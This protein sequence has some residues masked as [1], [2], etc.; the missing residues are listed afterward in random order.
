MLIEAGGPAAGAVND[1][2]D[3]YF[4]RKHTVGENVWRSLDDQFASTGYP[5]WTATSRIFLKSISS[6]AD[7]AGNKFCGL[8]AVF[9]DVRD[10]LIQIAPCIATQI[11]F[12]PSLSASSL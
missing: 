10:G 6:Q 1:C 8:S 3:F 9:E 12:M 7:S 11:T 4:L 2:N 5:A